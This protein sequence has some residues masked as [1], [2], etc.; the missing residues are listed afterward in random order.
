MH[1][2]TRSH[3]RSRSYIGAL[4]GDTL[5]HVIGL[6]P[7]RDILQMELVSTSWHRLIRDKMPAQMAAALAAD[8]AFDTNWLV[9][10]TV[11]MNLLA[12]RQDLQQA[13]IIGRHVAMLCKRLNY[14]N[15]NSAILRLAE[16][17]PTEVDVIRTINMPTMAKQIRCM[18]LPSHYQLRLIAALYSSPGHLVDLGF[19]MFACYAPDANNA[20]LMERVRRHHGARV[21]WESE[22]ELMECFAL[23]STIYTDACKNKGNTFIPVAQAYVATCPGR[24]PLADIGAAKVLGV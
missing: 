24:T 23:Y 13:T 18:C 4:P 10:S 6:L 1:R 22:R 19:A 3:T 17:F 2:R 20:P 11:L 16:V 12:R 5:C 21:L 7:V 15:C 8:P 14:I 9:V